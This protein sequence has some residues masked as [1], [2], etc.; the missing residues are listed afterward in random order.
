ME[1]LALIFCGVMFIVAV[2]CL[3]KDESGGIL[4]ALLAIILFAVMGATASAESNKESKPTEQQV[5][6]NLTPEEYNALIQ[7]NSKE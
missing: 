2:I 3:I 6:I 1:L 5:I 4:V 7:K